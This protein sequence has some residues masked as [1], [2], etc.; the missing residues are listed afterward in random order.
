MY[1]RGV[2][3]T[4][5]DDVLLKAGAGKSQLYHY[6]DTK[7]DLAAAVLEYQLAQVLDQLGGFRLQTWTG[8]RAWFAA[9][10]EAQKARGYSG[11]PVGSLAV[12]M[13]AISDDM[14]A[15]VATAFGRWQRVLE[16]KLAEM[17]ANGRLATGARTDDLAATTL[18]Q[19]QG[20]YLLSTAMQDIEPM[21]R[22]LEAAYQGL[23]A[24][25]R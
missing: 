11:C 6:F 10:V 25:A 13:T 5:I 4:S 7:E 3:V 23:R 19:I 22:A 16:E 12:E 9:L 24:R 8:I 21:E 2:H 20:G 18:A 15:R 14:A 1:E 17:Q